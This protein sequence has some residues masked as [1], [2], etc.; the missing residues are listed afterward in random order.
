MPAYT[1]IIKRHVEKDL[2]KIDRRYRK[3][4]FDAIESLIDNPRPSN[5]RKMTGADMT[6]RLRV[7]DYRVIYQVNDKERNITIFYIR[8]RKDAYKK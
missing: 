7:G 3:Q 4:I 8:H 1:I 5:S 6:H 2:R